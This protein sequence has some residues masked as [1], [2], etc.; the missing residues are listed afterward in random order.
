MDKLN[1]VKILDYWKQNMERVYDELD[2]IGS[3]EALKSLQDEM[4]ALRIPDRRTTRLKGVCLDRVLQASRELNIS[5]ANRWVSRYDALT[6]VME[7]HLK[8]HETLESIDA[9]DARKDPPV[10]EVEVYAEPY[11]SEH[12]GT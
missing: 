9:E 8:P 10:D 2:R 7:G 6:M 12:E 5:G 1:A 11:A 4:E 3:D